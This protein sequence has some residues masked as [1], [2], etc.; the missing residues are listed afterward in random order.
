MEENTYCV[1][2]HTLMIDNRKYIGIS[3]YGQCI[4]RRWQNGLGYKGNIY[5][6]RAI[7][8]YGWDSFKHELLYVN[9]SEAD[10][11]AKE[12]E[13]ISKFQTQDA[14]F[15]FNLDAGGTHTKHSEHTKEKMRAHSGRIILD[16]DVLM[17]LYI[18]QNLTIKQCAKYFNCCP[19]VVANNIKL[20][21]IVKP[22]ISV[23]YEDLYYQYI[24]LNK[25]QQDCASYFGCSKTT[26]ARFLKNYNIKKS[27][28]VLIEDIDAELLTKYYVEKNLS[29]VQIA[30][31][32]H[33]RPAV[34][35]NLLRNFNISKEHI[36][37][38]KLIIE[39]Q[40]LYDQYI[41][42]NKTIKE[43]ANYFNCG[44]NPISRL[45]KEYNISK[46]AELQYSLNSQKNLKFKILQEDL[47][48]RYNFLGLSRNELAHYYK[49]G[50]TTID[51]LLKKYN[52]KKDSLQKENNLV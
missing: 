5:F 10:A 7:K 43:I 14:R 25:S 44:T 17:D 26:I 46:S 30:K 13:L 33:R 16:E 37:Y 12:I 18:R 48:Y 42:Q 41:I 23:S 20:Y 35:S 8:K 9:L 2:M 19:P 50:K 32:F 28:R 24:K 51:R 27:T 6:W 45:L 3:K 22:R 36:P 11:C 38:N 47:Y 39:K 4:N 49:C 29:I 1:Y 21:K 52:I 15:G 40:V 34:I 31:I